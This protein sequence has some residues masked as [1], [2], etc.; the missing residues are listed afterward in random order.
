MCLGVPL[1][2]LGGQ[3]R[4]CGVGCVS[5]KVFRGSVPEH[6]PLSKAYNLFTLLGLRWIVVVGGVDGGTVVGVLTRESF[7]ES[8][9][10]E[11]TGMDP[12]AFQ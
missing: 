11:K 5:C 10:R 4:I 8:Y 7:S 9:L 12:R 1:R 2:S 3:W 6:F